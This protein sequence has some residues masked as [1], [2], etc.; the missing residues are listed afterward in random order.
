MPPGQTLM[1]TL[2]VCRDLDLQHSHPIFSLDCFGLRLSAISLNFVVKKTHT[3]SSEDTAE[4]R[5]F[6]TSAL[7]VA[8]TMTTFLLLTFPSFL[9][10]FLFGRGVVFSF[11]FFVLFSCFCCLSVAHATPPRDD[12]PAKNQAW[13]QNTERIRGYVLDKASTCGET[14]GQKGRRTR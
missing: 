4:S 13:L 10:S 2:N 5:I 11:S 8:L 14:V 3:M 12:A 7:T 9:F 1:E 6:I